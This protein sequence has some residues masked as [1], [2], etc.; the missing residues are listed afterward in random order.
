MPSFA[1]HLY[2]RPEVRVHVG[3]ARGFVA[4][5]AHR[6]D[7]IQIPLLDAFAWP[8]PTGTVSLNASFVYT[9]EAFETYLEHLEPG[10]YLAITRWLKLPPR[11]A[12]KLFL[13]GAASRSSAGASPSPR[14]SSP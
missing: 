4:A 8:R 6:Y 13:D 1:G 2:E 5:S 9:I 7:L 11:D 12:A 10:G 3:E 14:A